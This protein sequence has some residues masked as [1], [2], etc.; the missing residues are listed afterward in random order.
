MTNPII[1]VILCKTNTARIE[2]QEKLVYEIVVVVI[3]ILET[4]RVCF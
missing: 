2:N 1:R 4:F 3:I